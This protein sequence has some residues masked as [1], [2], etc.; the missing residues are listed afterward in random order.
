MGGDNERGEPTRRNP[1]P[2]GERSG[3]YGALTDV[4]ATEQEALASQLRVEDLKLSFT[5]IF[6]HATWPETALLAICTVCAMIAGGL[7]PFTP[8]ILTALF[9]DKNGIN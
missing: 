5:N 2:E 3:T 4:A 1:L 8:V 6:S 7:V 9:I